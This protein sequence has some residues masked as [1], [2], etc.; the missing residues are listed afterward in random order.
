[1]A[2]S[3]S[4]VKLP[5]A[6]LDKRKVER[7]R[8]LFRGRVAHLDGS[9]CI[10]CAIRDLSDTG[11]RVRVGAL[12]RLPD[13]VYLLDLRNRLAY[14]ASVSWRK[15]PDFGLHFLKRYDFDDALSPALRRLIKGELT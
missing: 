10:D 6:G 1:M 8:T 4:S 7:R 5:G 9:Y 2:P 11:A 13:A 15:S 3:A 12:Q 14:E